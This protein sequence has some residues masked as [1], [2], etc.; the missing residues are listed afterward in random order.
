MIGD[1]AARVQ[2]GLEQLERNRF[3]EAE[4]TFRSALAMNPRD[5]QLLH[6]LGIAQ[7][8]QGRGEE[9]LESVQRAIALTKRKAD[10][11][12]TLGF[13]LQSS[14]RI[15]EAIT[16]FERALKLRPDSSE[17]R[18]NLGQALLHARRHAEAQA[19]FE[20]ILAVTPADA[21]ALASLARAK[22]IAEEFES[23]VAVLREG[24]A[25]VQRNGRLRFS[26][27]ELLLALGDF[28]NGWREYLERPTRAG[29]LIRAGRRID[30]TPAAD[31]LPARLDGRTVK[32]YG[33]QG[34]GDEL[35]FLRFAAELRARGAARIEVAVDPRLVGIV[36]RSG[37]ADECVDKHLDLLREPDWIVTGDLP[38]LLGSTGPKLPAPLRLRPLGARMAEAR[39][40]LEGLARPLTGLT[41]RGGTSPATVDYAAPFKALPI[42]SVAEFAAA[43]PGTV[44]VLQ[45][46]PRPAELE[47]LAARTSGRMADLSMLNDD[48]EGMLALLAQIDEYVGV[49]N[50]NTHLHAGVG[51]RGRVLVS[52]DVE[53]RWMAR[54]TESP[55]FPGFKVYR[56]GP[57]GDW[58]RVF[59]RVL[60]DFGATGAR[61]ERTEGASR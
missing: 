2:K 9:A 35:F 7:L 17:V 30:Q 18:L 12:N 42:E 50:T 40:R 27:S 55:W 36:N 26:L 37:V 15:E 20:S 41:W 47:R 32:L 44:L 5:D 56:P 52:N 33:E 24:I 31:A 6:L 51:G 11:H 28:E 23:A 4:R 46:N 49:S 13:A 39:A 45:R 25:R 29:M 38:Y 61:H 10:Y 43:L 58:P 53:F 59:E 60:R 57:N 48:L 8:R 22:W 14:G 19:L 54:G 16:S 21:G 34:L 1:F 3:E